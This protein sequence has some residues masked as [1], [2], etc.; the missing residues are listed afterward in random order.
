[1][2]ALD[3]MS[4]GNP[5][6]AHAELLATATPLQYKRALPLVEVPSAAF[7]LTEL[8]ALKRL[9]AERDE[10][11]AFIER[12][13]KDFFSLYQELCDRL[14]VSFNTSEMH[15]L[16]EDST[17]PV[18]KLKYHF[19]R[20]RPYQVAHAIGDG[21]VPIET[22]SGHS[23]AYPSGHTTQSKLLSLT[24]AGRN[25][26]HAQA[27]HRLAWR[28]SWSRAQGGVHWPSDLRYGE[29]LADHLYSTTPT[30]IIV[31]HWRR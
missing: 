2:I 1:M 8:K 22:V 14:G 17:I 15:T 30:A 10:H 28:V 16:I 7:T 11:R 6:E 4:Y 12:A 5:N 24:L 21:F 27:F 29:L 25:P 13:D 9:V 26:E 18:L 19:N 23:P 31:A 3:E 20:P